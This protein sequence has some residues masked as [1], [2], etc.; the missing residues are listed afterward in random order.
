[1]LEGKSHHI[2]ATS[3]KHF[4]ASVIYRQHLFVSFCVFLSTKFDIKIYFI[5]YK[6]IAFLGKKFSRKPSAGVPLTYYHFRYS[7]ISIE[8]LTAKFLET[9][10]T[11]NEK[12]TY[13]KNGFLPCITLMETFT[14]KYTKTSEDKLQV[15]SMNEKDVCNVTNMS[16]MVYSNMGLTNLKYSKL[17][18]NNS[19]Y[20]IPS[21]RN[22]DI[23]RINYGW[24]SPW[25]YSTEL[26]ERNGIRPVVS[27]KSDLKTFG[28]DLNN[29]WNI[30]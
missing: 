23:W 5:L 26:R 10:F 29:F 27:L 19:V 21:T 17:F 14:N 22:S 20:W 6:L 4:I 9:T 15:R 12:R 8:N 28:F 13:I 7:D 3:H 25:P 18:D 2:R 30:Q 11:A 1:M 24:D 16:Q